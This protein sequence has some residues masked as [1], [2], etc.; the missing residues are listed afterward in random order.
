VSVEKRQAI[1]NKFF[2]ESKKLKT[3]LAKYIREN[4]DEFKHLK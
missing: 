4:R 2:G 3:I 1:D